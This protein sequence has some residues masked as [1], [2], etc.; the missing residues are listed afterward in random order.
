MNHR[1]CSD[2]PECV[3]MEKREHHLSGPMQSLLLVEGWI[4]PDTPAWGGRQLKP[5]ATPFRIGASNLV[6]SGQT[7]SNLVKFHTLLHIRQFWKTKAKQQLRLIMSKQLK[8]AKHN[9]YIKCFVG[10]A[11]VARGAGREERGAAPQGHGD[12]YC[13]PFPPSPP[14]PCL[15]T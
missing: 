5:P 13:A 4:P 3:S 12:R 7:N 2:F 15:F 10:G 9:K 14:P 11:P 8:F 6:K 1:M